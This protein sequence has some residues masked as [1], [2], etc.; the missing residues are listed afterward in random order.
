MK[1]LFYCFAIFL[2]VSPAI[3]ADSKANSAD[4]KPKVADSK[5]VKA[6]VKDKIDSKASAGDSKAD[7]TDSKTKIVDSKIAA[8]DAKGK[9]GDSKASIVDSKT[10]ATDLKGKIKSAAG[11]KSSDTDDEAFELDLETVFSLIECENLTVLLNREKIEQA[12]QDAYIRR[13]DLFPQVNT[14]LTQTRDRLVVPVGGNVEFGYYINRFDGLLN[15][16]LAV[17]DLNKIAGYR[18]AK[19]GWQISALNYNAI[20]QDILTATGK[21]YYLHIR[22][23]KALDVTDANIEEA[24]VLLDLAQARFNAGVA[25]PIDVTKAEVQLAIYK[26]DRLS[27]EIIIKQSELELKRVLDIDVHLPI[28]VSYTDESDKP[29]PKPNLEKPPIGTVFDNRFDYQ[30]AY[31]QLERNR[32][33]YK[34]AGW[35]SYPVVNTFGNF[36]YASG[37]AFQNNAEKEW[38]IGIGISMPILDGFRILSNV[39]QK[40]SLVR[41]QQTVV[42][43]V[44]NTIN[45]EFT[46][47][48]Y[49]LEVRYSEIELIRKQVELGQQELDLAKTRF[50]EGVADN[51]D[52][53]TAQTNLATFMDNLVNILYLY[54]V[55]R[56][57]WARTLGDV[58][59][60]L[61]DAK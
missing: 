34:A 56:L 40:A 48:A 54:D 19:M 43:D 5:V 32:Y 35:A 8:A 7:V 38:Q 47:N 11:S 13:A 49:T 31:G 58:R 1:A 59:N 16:S 24:Q 14:T 36:G 30:T 18:S 26:R 50:K 51:T 28:K 20:L 21:L 57:E 10:K 22:N 29:R 12:L 25:S 46:L 3:A 41:Q 44:I 9:E 2:L 15:G 4:S 23:L 33:D 53:V 61:C 60:V 39:L 55:S 17:F 52:I 37:Y 6:E 42:Q 27:Q 45:T